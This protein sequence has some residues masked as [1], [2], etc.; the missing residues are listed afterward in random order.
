MLLVDTVDRLLSRTEYNTLYIPFTML[1][2]RDYNEVYTRGSRKDFL[3]NY[4]HIKDPCQV[5]KA[6][7]LSAGSCDIKKKKLC[8]S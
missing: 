2:V 3:A 4:K 7:A 1:S 5:N 6:I 8:Q